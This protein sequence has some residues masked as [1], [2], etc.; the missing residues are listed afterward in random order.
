MPIRYVAAS[1]VGLFV[2]LGWNVFLAHR[3]VQ[4]FRANDQRAAEV[5]TMV[6][7]FQYDCK[8]KTH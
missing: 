7:D 4:L 6:A 8:K 5:C 2:I 3:D 1:A